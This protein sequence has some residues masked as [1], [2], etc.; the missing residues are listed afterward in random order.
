MAVLSVLPLAASRIDVTGQTYANVHSGASVIVEFGVSNYGLNNKGFSPY[1]TGI[2]LNIVVQAPDQETEM[3][4]WSSASYYSGYL[5]DGWL[6]S[7]DGSAIIPLED[8]LAM[9]LGYGVGKVALGSGVFSGSA[10]S[11]LTVGVLSASVHLTLEQSQQIFGEGFAARIVLHNIGQSMTLGIGPGYTIRSAVTEPGIT[12]FG[13]VSV[14]GMT[15]TVTVA[16]PEP[17]T[18]MLGAG[19]VVLFAISSLRSSA[20]RARKR[21]NSRV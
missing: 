15:R 9:L 1:P 4:P 20:A 10:V 21:A 19:A 3:A 13:P 11:D 18:W 16:N 2:N 6:E 17:S 7:L 5:F 12:G 14:G 8:S